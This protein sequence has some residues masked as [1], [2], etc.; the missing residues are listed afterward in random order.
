MNNLFEQSNIQA[1]CNIC[2]VDEPFYMPVIRTDM[3]NLRLQVPYHLVT[4]NSGGLP[5]GASVRMDM[6]NEVGT[7][8]LCSMGNASGGRYIFGNYNDTANKKA[9]YQFFF[10]VPFKDQIGDN[11]SHYYFDVNVGQHV[12]ITGTGTDADTE[13]TYGVDDLPAVFQEIRPGRVIFPYFVGS[14]AIAVQLNGTPITFFSPYTA[15]TCPHEN[16][17]C[18]RVKISVTFSVAGVTKEFFT[19]PFRVVRE[20]EDTIRIGAIYPAGQTDCNGYVH[21]GSMVPNIAD[22]NILYLRMFANLDRSANKVKKIYNNKCFSIKAERT[23]MYKLN[24]PPVPTWFA[25][26][27]ENLLIAKETTYNNVPLLLQDTDQLFQQQGIQ[28][29]TYQH[30]DVLLNSCKCEITYS[31]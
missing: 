4:A 13:W 1:N 10:P 19:K 28:G 30:L 22:R 31:C 9:E 17:N 3:M 16:F 2:G 21:A 8:V 26:E 24:T 25:D 20:C 12:K 7:T 14:P 11:Y 29:Y 15:S 18:W 6:V 27:V 23:P 5:I